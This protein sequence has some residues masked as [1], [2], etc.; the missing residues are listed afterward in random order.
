M[1][2]NE[3][4]QVVNEIVAVYEQG[5]VN[6]EKALEQ[7]GE[8]RKEIEKKIGEALSK[9][10]EAACE[11]IGISYGD[12]SNIIANPAT[13]GVSAAADAIIGAGKAAVGTASELDT[14]MD[15]FVITIGAG[16]E[17]AQR[18]QAILEEV[19]KNNYG[20]SFADIA[21]AMAEL[22]AIGGTEEWS[23]AGIQEILESAFFLRDTFAYD[24][25]DSMQ[26]AKTLM[27]SFGVDGSKAM[28]LIA[29]GAR[30]GLDSSGELL[31]SI[32]A[33]SAQ[34]SEIGMNADDMFQIFQAG[35]QT[36]AFELG[37][38]GEAIGEMSA[39]L[40]DGSEEATEGFEI[41]GL[42]AEEMTEKFMAGGDSAREAFQQTV[43]A[44]AGM[45]DPIAQNT[46]GLDLFGTAWEELGPE[47][48]DALAGIEEGIY[49]VGDEMESLQELGG[50]NLGAQLEEL[51]RN[52]EMLLVPLGEQLIPILSQI[53]EEILPPLMEILQPLVELVG[54]ILEPL[55]TLVSEVLTPIMEIVA[56]LIEPL[57]ELMESCLTPLF[58]L[59]QGL[60]E[61]LLQLVETC[62]TPLLDMV[63]QL[64]DPLFQ[65]ISEILPPLTE[66]FAGLLEPVITLVETALRPF[67][68]ILQPIVDAISLMMIPALGSLMNKFD[69][70]F[71]NVSEFVSRHM[72]NV[73][74]VLENVIDFIKNVF[75]GNWEEAWENVKNIFSAIADSLGSIF[76]PPVNAIIDVLNG[77]IRGINKIQIPDWIPAIGGKGFHIPEIPR[78]K[79][80]EDFIPRDWYAA[81]LDH[82]ERVMTASE[83]AKF[84]AMGGLEGMERALSMDRFAAGE[85][86]ITVIVPV[87]IDGREVARSTAEYIGEQQYWEDL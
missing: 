80:G 70:V 74:A 27:D 37:T 85:K 20:D 73:M 44:L 67:L 29:E 71:T 66:L 83:N 55:L 50:D 35:A 63:L 40:K 81:Y 5:N 18:Y 51:Q 43:D 34:F 68:D 59:I 23:D 75:T 46:A 41:L 86:K 33:Y 13:A 30:N 14:V 21:D 8:R 56:S 36:G 45:E 65:F 38:V 58:D 42:N 82:G 31:D 61:P 57:T 76:K 11:Q 32:S 24:V 48:V 17:E 62:L 49:A 39:R 78:L 84:N 79:E 6:I 7:S 64:L 28:S 77:F 16:E 26:A 53:M 47:A 25:A 3:V 1:A 2:N 87:D 19:Y 9:T 10:A 60:L 69:E 54:A 72:G 4:G 15:Q 12:I 52:V 22:T